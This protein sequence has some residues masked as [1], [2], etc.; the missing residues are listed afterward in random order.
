M[1]KEANVKLVQSLGALAFTPLLASAVPAA[2]KVGGVYPLTHGIYVQEGTSCKGAPNAAIRTYDGGGI[3]DPH[4]HACLTHVLLRQGRRYSVTQSCIDAGVGSGPRISERQ[5]VT[6]SNA[7]SFTIATG[8]Q[9][10]GYRYCP[11]VF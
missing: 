8:G 11:V 1:H 2:A 5:I 3:G 6:V 10:L 4:S 9:G 7:T